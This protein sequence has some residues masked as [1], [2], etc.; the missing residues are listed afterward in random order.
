MKEMAG[1]R[2]LML[3]SAVASWA[4]KPTAWATA[5]A[6][7]TMHGGESQSYQANGDGG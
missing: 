6:C 7:G 3:R 4:V 2:V 5:A 1:S